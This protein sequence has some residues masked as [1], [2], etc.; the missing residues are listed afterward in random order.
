MTGVMIGRHS[1][2]NCLRE[3][4]PD[5]AI[6]KRKVR[7]VIKRKGSGRNVIVFAD[8]DTGDEEADLVIGADGLRSV[9]RKA[10]FRDD[11]KEMYEAHY[12]SVMRSSIQSH[13]GYSQKS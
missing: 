8:G 13:L 1:L 11:G 10:I 3:E 7:E 9:V 12:E 5:A 6:V 4:V 2:W